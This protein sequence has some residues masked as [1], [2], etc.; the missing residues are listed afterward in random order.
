M[1]ANQLQRLPDRHYA[2]KVG[3]HWYQRVQVVPDLSR[4]VASDAAVTAA[5]AAAMSG[6][7]PVSDI[8][9]EIARRTAREGRTGGP[10]PPER[11]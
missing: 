7:R 5:K 8:F 9:A 4:Y 6:T 3:T 1:V 10:P 11:A 2:L